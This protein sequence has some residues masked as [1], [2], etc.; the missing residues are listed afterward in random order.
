MIIDRRGY[1]KFVAGVRVVS[2]EKWTIIQSM[3][4][5]F[6]RLLCLT[7]RL[8]RLGSGCLKIRDRSQR[9]SI[10]DVIMAWKR[11]EELSKEELAEIVTSFKKKAR[12]LVDENLGP[13]VVGVLREL[14]WNT[15]SVEDEGYRGHADESVFALA[16]REKRILV[17]K[18]RDFLDDR[19]FPEHRNP[20]VIILPDAPIESQK[21]IATLRNLH[22]LIAPMARAYHK[23]KVDLS[24][25][26]VISV[27]SRNDNTGAI[28]TSRYRIARDGNVEIWED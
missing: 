24:D 7:T 14:G 2:G 17:T 16:W 25:P 3:D 8:W 9:I 4:C 13:F 10:C 12:F 22:K 15:V 20:G 28:E 27:R 5:L 18:D 21:F 1:G 19:R 6:Y 23:A 11:L 26:E